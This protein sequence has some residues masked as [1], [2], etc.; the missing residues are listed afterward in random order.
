M[1]MLSSDVIIDESNGPAV[2][3]GVDG[4]QGSRQEEANGASAKGL[5]NTPPPR[6]PLT[7][8]PLSMPA[9]VFDFGG[10][11]TVGLAMRRGRGELPNWDRTASRLLRA[12][13]TAGPA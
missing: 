6:L 12:S 9:P 13:A 5:E 10:G 4:L 11:G 7:S 2:D 1:H 3:S 8:L